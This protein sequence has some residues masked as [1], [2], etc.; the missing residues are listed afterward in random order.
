MK[1]PRPAGAEQAATPPARSV[2]EL[3]QLAFSLA[4]IHASRTWSWPLF[5]L[6]LLLASLTLCF[7]LLFPSFA[8]FL[9]VSSPLPSTPYI[10][11][12]LLYLS[13]ASPYLISLAAARSID[14]KLRALPPPQLEL[15]TLLGL[16]Q[17]CTST[18]TTSTYAVSRPHLRKRRTSTAA[19]PLHVDTTPTA[20]RPAAVSTSTA[21]VWSHAA[22]PVGSVLEPARGGG[23]YL[24]PVPVQ[25]RLE[26]RAGYSYSPSRVSTS[27]TVN[28]STALSRLNLNCSVASVHETGEAI[29]AHVTSVVTRFKSETAAEVQPY[30]NLPWR[31]STAAQRSCTWTALTSLHL[32]DEVLF[33]AFTAQV[34]AV[35]APHGSSRPFTD[36]HVVQVAP[37]VESSIPSHV[38]D[39]MTSTDA[40]PRIRVHAEVRFKSGD[41]ARI[42]LHMDDGFTRLCLL[43]PNAPTAAAVMA[44][45]LLSATPACECGCGT[46][47][48][49]SLL[50]GMLRSGA[51]TVNTQQ[52]WQQDD[53]LY[54]LLRD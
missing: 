35:L 25:P 5:L 7:C 31:T 2:D 1:P 18:G 15:L 16:P 38:L 51:H 27:T 11:L 19:A 23:V 14:L 54:A 50:R 34:D 32:S 3:K 24:N 52:H 36:A 8:P 46:A 49:Q 43:A 17:P 10:I 13:A 37:Q 20:A 30:L 26:A 21:A 12:S 28:L 33:N 4:S 29:A 22:V 45:A 48:V 44:L 9:R 41:A 39:G 47:G 6:S 40:S 42:L 53:D